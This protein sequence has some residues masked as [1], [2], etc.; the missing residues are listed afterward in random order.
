MLL[1]AGAAGKH[2]IDSVFVDI[3]DLGGLA[4]EAAGAVACGFA[5][6]ACIHPNQVKIVRDAYAPTA[7]DVLAASQLLKAAANTGNGVFSFNGKMI[8][9]PILKQADA[10][11]SMAAL[12]K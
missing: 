5:S 1:A 9:G 3:A 2:V 8:D 6:K 7:E 10:T 4:L 11:L 12:M